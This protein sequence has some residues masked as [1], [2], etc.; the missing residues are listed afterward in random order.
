MILEINRFRAVVKVHMFVQ[1]FIELSAAVHELSCA[2]PMKTLQSVRYRTESEN[3][4][5]KLKIKNK[6][7]KI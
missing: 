2:T 6:S 3:K 1:N 5:V 4:V 7:N